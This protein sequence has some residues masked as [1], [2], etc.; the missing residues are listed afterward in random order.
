M[1]E[2]INKKSDLI[3][4]SKLNKLIKKVTQDI[5]EFKFNNAVISLMEFV[6]YIKQHNYGK[7]V[8]EKLVLLISPFAPHLA[9]EMHEKLGNKNF[10]SLANWP[11]VNESKINE[12][13]EKQEE[14]IN[15]TID[16]ILNIKKLANIDNPKTYL[17]VIPKELKLFQENKNI[18]K[19]KTD[20]KDIKIFA[21]NDKDKYDPKHKAMKAKPGKPAIYL[22]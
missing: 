8:L 5:E 1:Q 18:I 6:D 4:E 12:E 7:D 22:E 17:Y 11:K 2:N 10:V 19:D 15:K 14:I 16:D 13:L 9:E 20:S 3:V 21:V